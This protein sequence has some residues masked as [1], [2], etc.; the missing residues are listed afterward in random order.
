MEIRNKSFLRW[1]EKLR[2]KCYYVFALNKIH[3]SLIV[4]IALNIEK[5]IAHPTST[6][7]S[8]LLCFYYFEQN[9][10]HCWKNSTFLKED[11]EMAPIISSHLLLKFL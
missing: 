8:Y 10:N 1:K 5:I 4:E 6:P 11:D 7:P 9:W 3:A 2:E